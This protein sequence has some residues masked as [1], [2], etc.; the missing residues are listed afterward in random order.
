MLDVVYHYRTREVRGLLLHHVLCTA[1]L[2]TDPR[3]RPATSLL[4]YRTRAT[5]VSPASRTRRSTRRP[6]RR[7]VQL[8]NCGRGAGFIVHRNRTIPNQ[9]VGLV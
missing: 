5:G 1:L 8:L 7:C 2:P 4:G 9:S 3:L 6:K